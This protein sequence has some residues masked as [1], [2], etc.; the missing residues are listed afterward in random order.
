MEENMMRLKNGVP[1]ILCILGATAAVNA[2]V[3]TQYNFE[4]YAPTAGTANPVNGTSS[5]AI[6]ADVG[7][8]T[9]TLTH[10]VSSTYSTPAGNGTPKSLSSTTW[11]LGDNYIFNS[12]AT[13]TPGL[14]LEYAQTSSST[15]PINFM[16]Q[17]SVDGGTTFVTP[18]NGA[19]SVNP[20]NSF[21][22][23][24]VKTNSPPTFFFDFTGNTAV[25]TASNVVFKITDLSLTGASGG[26]S[27]I[28]T[29]TVGTNLPAPTVPEPTTLCVIAGGVSLLLGRR[30]RRI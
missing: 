5:G 29:V 4:S 3:I 30:S 13:P 17:Y 16:L 6:A 25:E 27:R 18:S 26:T 8:G 1:A 7:T 10:S 23:G 20:S 11:S 9:L 24:A 12:A 15:G 28:D 22:A 14:Q 2:A 21:S 19:Y